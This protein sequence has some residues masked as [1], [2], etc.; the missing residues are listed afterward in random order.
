MNRKFFDWVEDYPTPEEA[1]V[2]LFGVP[3]GRWSKQALENWR[4][5]SNYIEIYDDEKRKNL[6]D[7][8]GIADIGN[9]DVRDYP[10]FEKISEKVKE[11]LS[12]G[13]LPVIIG[14][15][16]LL[17]YY[18][19]KVFPE[20]TR[21]LV[22]DAHCDIKNSFM[23]EK[24]V[25]LDYI[26]ENFKVDTKINDTTWVRRVCDIRNPK[27]IMQ[28]GLRSGDEFDFKFIRENGITMITPNMLHRDIEKSKRVVEQFTEGHDVYVSVDIDA[29][30]PSI[31]PAVDHPEP[32]GIRFDEF[33]E[34][35]SAVKGKIVGV[36][37]VCLKPIPN[38]EVTEFTGIRGLFEILNK[39]GEQFKS[40][41]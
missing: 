17:S 6:L 16:H 14:G 11:I 24:I 19:F 39:Y 23:D 35:I 12:K 15:G 38:N 25:D 7:G 20:S 10:D 27:N 40:S 9:V 28:I 29:F 36:D 31:A 33:Q 41:A 18:S 1:N 13:K 32:N 3:I 4:H 26:D 5:A 21:L 22:F 30:D 2:I 8:M 37:L 34:V